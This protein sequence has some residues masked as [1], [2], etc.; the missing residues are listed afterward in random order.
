MVRISKDELKYL[1]SKGVKWKNNG[2]SHT[3]T[4]HHHYYLTES[5]RNMALLEKY[6]ESRK[7]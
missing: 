7:V 6:R 2:I 4:K 1:L 5:Q 3:Y